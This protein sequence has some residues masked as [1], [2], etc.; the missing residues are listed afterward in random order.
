MAEYIIVVALLVEI[1]HLSQCLEHL[2]GVRHCARRR[3]HHSSR[4]QT[5]LPLSWCSPCGRKRDDQTNKCKMANV[6]NVTMGGTLSF[7]KTY[8]ETPG[9]LSRQTK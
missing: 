1:G 6:E 9:C 8:Q 2:Q 4:A 3:V 5:Q 7:K